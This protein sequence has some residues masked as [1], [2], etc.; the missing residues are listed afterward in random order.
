MHG[1]MQCF[2]KRQNTLDPILQC[3][4]RQTLYKALYPYFE[5]NKKNKKTIYLRP[6][7]AV[8]NKII[9]LRRSV[10]AVFLQKTI[11]LRPSRVV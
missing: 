11:Y 2:N 7:C 10:C 9:E 1:I 6:F 3:L 5:R 4:V 8:F